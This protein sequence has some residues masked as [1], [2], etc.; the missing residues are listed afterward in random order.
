MTKKLILL[1]ALFLGASVSLWAYENTYA[2]VIGV[3]DYKNYSPD[4]GDLNYTINDA[5]SFAAF[6]KS[7]KGGSVPASNIVLLIDS[8]ASKA[9]IITKAKNLFAKAKRN[10]RVIF[11]F[12]GH[13]SKGCFV[14]YDVDIMGSNLLYFDEVKAIFRC[15]KCNTKLLFADACFSGSMKT[16]LLSKTNMKKSLEKSIKAASNINIAVMMSCQDDEFSI[17]SS[18]L[19]QGLF[20]YYLMEG[21]GGKA[22]RDGNKYITIQELYYYVYH[23]VQDRT[24]NQTPQLFGKFDLRLIVAKV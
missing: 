17:E 22:N 16:E 1:L 9:N 14:P 12:S 4:D 2:I 18:D 24:I 3:A 23:K 5:T 10:D 20:T 15:A 21:L 13:G 7:K 19:R 11:Y 8:Q 6:L